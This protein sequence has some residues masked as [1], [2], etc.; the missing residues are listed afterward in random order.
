MMFRMKTHWSL[1]LIF[2][3]LFHLQADEQDYYLRLKK[4]WQ[5]MREVYLQLNQH[6]VEDVDP[7]PLIKAGINGMLDKLDPYTV[8][9]DEN[10]E[11]RLRIITTGKYGGLGMEVGLRNKKITVISPIEGTPAQRMGIRAGDIIEKVDDQ[12]VSGWSIEQVSGKLRGKVG[13]RVKL[14]LRRPGLEKP[15]EL[16]LTREEIIIKD[17]SYSDFVAPGI[18]YV[19]LS[20]FTEKAA[21]ELKLAIKELQDRGEIKAFILDLRGNPGG[22]LKSAVD[23]VNVFVP[24]GKLVVYTKGF[25]EKEA[26]FYTNKIPVLPDVPLAVLVD[27]GSASASEIVAGALQDMDRAVIVGE[28]TFGKGL[29]QKVYTLDDQFDGKLKITTA[30]Y[31]VPSGR[32]IQ[33][34]DY[35][36]NNNVFIRDSS[37][38]DSSTHVYFTENKRKVYDHGG[39]YPDV[40]VRQDSMNYIVVD[41]IRKNLLFDFAVDY[42]QKHPEWQGDFII[43]DAIMDQFAAYLKEKNFKPTMIVD[44]ELDKVKKIAQREGYSEK[45]LQLIKQLRDQFAGERKAIYRNNLE[46]IR[47]LLRLELAEKYYGKDFR[48]KLSLEDDRQAQETIRILQNQA[49]YKDILA[50]Q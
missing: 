9:I 25:R 31:Y 30:K 42:H 1:L 19:T 13:T 34:R 45:T 32:C 14:L 36:Q 28:P 5:Y 46:Q 18:A 4:G 37:A 27:G 23:V 44:K 49:Q 16:V 33:K 7:Y 17:V 15:F 43:S 2:V 6:Y 8:F 10:G 20:G 48:Q 40:T 50:I 26:R 21:A 24:K 3:F 41:L 22:L 39:I 12:S 29:V 35:G 11:R 38:T 47:V